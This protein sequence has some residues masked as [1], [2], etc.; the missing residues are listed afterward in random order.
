MIGHT[1]IWME[2]AKIYVTQII[3]GIFQL[4]HV[5]HALQLLI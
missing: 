4:E 2:L 5:K 3:I 1:L